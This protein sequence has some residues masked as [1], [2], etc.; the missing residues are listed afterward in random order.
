[1]SA[2]Y[3]LGVNIGFHD[4]SAALLRDGA[5]C[6]LVEQERVSR[7]KH[8]VGQPPAE[9]VAACLAMAGIGP[10]DVD[11]LAIGWDFRQIPLG[12]NRR[13]TTDGL[14]AMLFPDQEDLVM[15]AVRWVPHHV[16]HAASAAFSCDTDE[17]AV[18]VVDGAGET[19]STSIG[20]FADG[21]V[22]ILRE[23]PV[24]ESLGFY[25][26]AAAEWA[27][28]GYWG[29]GKLMGLAA[30]GRAASGAPVRAVPG[31]YELVR[32]PA[33]QVPARRIA[34]LGPLMAYYPAVAE[35]LRPGFGAFFPYAPRE[36]E[37]PIAYAD[38]A[39]TV[40][41][42]LEE[43]VLSLATELRRRVD[44]PVLA[45]AGGVAMNCT[46]IGVLVRSGLFDRVY[47][48]PVPTDAG[49][50]LG[51]ALV[52]ARECGPFTPTR[53]DHAYWGRPVTTEAGESAAARAGLAHRRLGDDA[54]ARFVAGE[55]ARGRI[56]GWARGRGEI[57][58]RALGARSLLADPR[59]RR[60]LE[61]LNVLKGREMWRPVAPSMLAEHAHELIEGR[62]DDPSRFMLAAASVRPDARRRIPAVT[63]VDGSARPQ[64]VHRDTNPGYWALIEQFRQLTGVPA[65]VNTSFNLAGDPIVDSATDA[66]D[67]FTRA[68]E[69]DLLV[70]GDTVVTRGEDDLPA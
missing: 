61:R 43:A 10:A 53:I 29:T 11:T 3:V 65:V 2:R 33:A 4:S 46:M 20:R 41:Q 18:L 17:A 40:Q 34:S 24:E 55:I 56:V 63:H 23:W 51:A 54:L 62:L 8:A 21:E 27:G 13:F 1:M 67:T 70:L 28:L 52:S 32:A 49:V 14:R 64:T 7:R 22:E 16:A 39:A 6:A 48:P 66:V 36:A 44:T 38:F 69:I 25:Y 59:D 30:Y 47:V 15:P 60:S 9:A 31:G 42:G 26:N 19:Q 45:L 68:K 50:S 35:S 58:Q 12:R 57:G 37:E 5:L